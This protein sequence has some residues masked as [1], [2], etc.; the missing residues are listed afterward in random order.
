MLLSQAECLL[1]PSELQHCQSLYRED[2]G[3]FTSNC[4]T[5]L[6]AIRRLTDASVDIDTLVSLLASWWAEIVA[7]EPLLN[8]EYL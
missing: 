2:S 1:T 5:Y 8:T 4:T 3:T 7:A 6:S